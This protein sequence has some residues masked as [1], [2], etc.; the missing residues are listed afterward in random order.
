M[1]LNDR[2]NACLTI[3]K[4]KLTSS[5]ID[6]EEAKRI[7]TEI[8]SS[9]GV[10]AGYYIDE[11]YYNY[12]AYC[13]VSRGNFANAFRV[14]SI[15]AFLNE[16]KSDEVLFE[17]MDLVCKM[18]FDTE[19]FYIDRNIILKNIKKVKDNLYEVSPVIKKYFWV[20]PYTNIGGADKV[21]EDV[22]HEGKR[23]I[24]MSQYNKSN[25]LKT[26]NKIE[27]AVNLLIEEGNKDN[28]FL[29]MS[30]IEE[31]SGV[32]KETI[33]NVYALFKKD[34]D[35]YNT[36]VF[37]TSVYTD[38]VKISNVF[39]I[40]SSINKFKEEMEIKLTKRKIAYKS[41]LHVNTVYNLWLEDEVQDSLDEYN[42][43]LRGYRKQM[44]Q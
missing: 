12:S 18:Y 7:G 28:S 36:N 15:V 35:K 44:K 33:S 16:D 37:K 23:R 19:S 30:D 27:N 13:N 17:Y 6:L 10:L 40:S 21:I 2:L 25:R 4:L 32:P 38:F 14:S 31:L 24:V 42:V 3:N 11:G 39:T 34:I 8:Y 5:E 22:L 43:W 29:T 26:L 20:R 41:N 1:E 9:S